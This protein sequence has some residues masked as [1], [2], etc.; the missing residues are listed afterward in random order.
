MQCYMKALL[1]FLGLVK[2]VKAGVLESSVLLR[3]QNLVD[4]MKEVTELNRQCNNTVS[5]YTTTVENLKAEN[6]DLKTS[7]NELKATVD[8]LNTTLTVMQGKIII[9]GLF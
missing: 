6:E 1:Q 3:M 8:V 5:N 7:N 2:L 4:S 9:L